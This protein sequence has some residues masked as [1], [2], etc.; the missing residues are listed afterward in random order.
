MILLYKQG[1]KEE[2]TGYG[3]HTGVTS[4]VLKKLWVQMVKNMRREGEKIKKP[5]RA[6]ND[7]QSL[8]IIMCPELKEEV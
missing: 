7:M 4:K 3:L 1:R 5:G 6:D 2:G 8:H